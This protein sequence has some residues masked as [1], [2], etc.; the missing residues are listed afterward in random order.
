MPHIRMR[1]Q[2]EEILCRLS[3]DLLPE[4]ALITGTPLAHFTLEG[5]E[6]QC[7]SGGARS[8]GDAFCEVLWFDRGQEMQ[9]RVA[10]KITEALK[11]ESSGADVVVV[12]TPLAKSSYYEN[13]EHF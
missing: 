13:G 3:R 10:R 11:K 9:D 5:I 6:S 4:L 7:Y 2:S 12:F 1:F 8:Q